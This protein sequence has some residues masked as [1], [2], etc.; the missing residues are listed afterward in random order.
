MFDAT[1]SNTDTD[2]DTDNHIRITN[3]NCSNDDTN[4][5]YNIFKQ[6]F[7]TGK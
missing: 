4:N 1:D 6:R 3:L 7:T 5:K 2:T